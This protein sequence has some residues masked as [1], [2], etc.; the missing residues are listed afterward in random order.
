MT[1]DDII[2]GADKLLDKLGLKSFH[3]AMTEV[4]VSFGFGRESAAY[5]TAAM[6]IF[7][8]LGVV[9]YLGAPKDTSTTNSDDTTK[10]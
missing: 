5:A 10:K 3:D 2:L 4:L 9:G 1:I 7:I 8:I 6:Y